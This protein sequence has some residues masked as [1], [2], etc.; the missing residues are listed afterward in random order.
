MSIEALAL[1]SIEPVMSSSLSPRRRALGLIR[2]DI[3]IADAYGALIY[4][5]LH[6]MVVAVPP[7]KL[8]PSFTSLYRLLLRT[9]SAAV[10]HHKAATRYVKTLWKP[11]FREAAT[12]VRKL[13]DPKFGTAEKA[14]LEKWLCLWESSRVYQRSLRIELIVRPPV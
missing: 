14:Q 8:P 12:I 4:W 3:R 10:L 6:S 7:H 13:Q 5:S 1:E 2:P 11:S 9:S